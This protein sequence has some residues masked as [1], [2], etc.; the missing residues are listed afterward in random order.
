[1]TAIADQSPKGRDRNGLD[2][3]HASGGGVSQSPEPQ[4]NM[5]DTTK[6]ELLPLHRWLGDLSDDDVEMLRLVLQGQRAT[7]PALDARCRRVAAMLDATTNQSQPDHTANGDGLVEQVAAWQ[8]EWE[9]ADGPHWGDKI[10]WGTAR[11]IAERLAALAAS[12]TQVERQGYVAIVPPDC[13]RIAWRGTVYGLDA[14][15]PPSLPSMDQ[16]SGDE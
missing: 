11:E 12:P 7:S 15:A 10:E 4:G 2:A 5:S 1:M 3:K 14:L 13:D 8:L 16:G 9:R 6:P